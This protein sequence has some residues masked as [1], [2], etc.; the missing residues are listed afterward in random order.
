[1]LNT[2][3]GTLILQFRIIEVQ[4]VPLI[5]L[6]DTEDMYNHDI[7]ATVLHSGGNSGGNFSQKY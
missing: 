7:S 2:N 5:V 4:F 6:A 1:M 3:I